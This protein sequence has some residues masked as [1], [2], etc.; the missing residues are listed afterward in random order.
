MQKPL[1]GRVALV[2]GAS[3]GIGEGIA[4]SLAEAGVKV[5]V[6]ARRAERLE[7]LVQKITAA[8]SEGLVLAGDITNDDF[9]RDVVAQTVKK[10]GRLDILVNSAGVM[11]FGNVENADMAAWRRLMELNLFATVATCSAALPIMRAQGGGDIFNISS[12]G[13]RRSTGGPYSSSKFALTSMND[14]MRAEASP[15]GV[16]VCIIEPGATRSE[17]AENVSNPKM[18]ETLRKHVTRDTA[19]EPEDIGAVVV[20]A[21]SLPPEVNI[22]QVMI[23]PTNDINPLYINLP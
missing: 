7:G 19:M 13:G 11:E 6:S 3:S 8:G 20:L 21:C 1:A 22:S 23:R 10:F 12:T 18:R 5:A 14:G 2:T 15:Y 16:R 17:V 9:A 4:L